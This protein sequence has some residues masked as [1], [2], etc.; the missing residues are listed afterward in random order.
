MIKKS[1][2]ML[3]LLATASLAF[4]QATVGSGPL[5]AQP[6]PLQMPSHVEH[7]DYTPLGLEHSLIEKSAYTFA[8]G[9]RPLWEVSPLAE[10]IPLGDIARALREEHMKAPRA[11][12]VKEN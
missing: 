6:V 5:S 12:F 11:Q 10:E 9:E 7:A 3:F 2:F 4:G 1:V 8:R